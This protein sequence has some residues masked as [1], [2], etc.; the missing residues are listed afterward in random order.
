MC[1]EFPLLFFLFLS[2]SA[3]AARLLSIKALRPP[4][5]LCLTHLF[6]SAAM[7]ASPLIPSRS[8]ALSLYRSLLRIARKFADYNV[9]EYAKRRTVDGFRQNRGLS[10]PSAIASAFSDGKSQLEVAKRQAVLYS[11]YAPKVKSIMEAHKA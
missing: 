2:S 10:D 7:S 1:L 8:E 5:Y 4:L 6:L 3:L 9:R 11:L